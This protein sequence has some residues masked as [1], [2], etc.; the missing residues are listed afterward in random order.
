MRLPVNRW[1]RCRSSASSLRLPRWRLATTTTMTS[2]G[3]VTIPDRVPPAPATPPSTTGRRPRPRVPPMRIFFPARTRAPVRCWTSG[4]AAMRRRVRIGKERRMRN[5]KWTEG[6]M[7]WGTSG[8]WSDRRRLS[9]R[10]S[11]YWLWWSR[12]SSRWNRISSSRNPTAYVLPLFEMNCSCVVGD[13]WAASPTCYPLRL[14]IN[15][16]NLNSFFNV[17]ELVS[18]TASRSVQPLLHSTYV[19]PTRRQID[20]DAAYC[21]KCRT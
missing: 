14:Q 15:L 19:R 12:S 6:T 16:S 8:P 18:Q 2:P 13:F 7:W 20:R 10:S 21:Y 4:R 1:R 5:R 9:T 3:A 17:H 11:A